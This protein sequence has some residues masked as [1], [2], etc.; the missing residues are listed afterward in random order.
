[1]RTSLR[2]R[3]APALA[4][5]VAA[6]AFSAVASASASASSWVQGETSM[7]WTSPSITL[8]SN[9]TNVSCSLSSAT[10]TT[11]SG[12]AGLVYNSEYFRT[13]LTCPGKPQL[14]FLAYFEV[15]PKNGDGTYPIYMWNLWSGSYLLA[16]SPF[17]EYIQET[18]YG[19]TQGTF[20]NGTGG[21]A[22]TITFQNDVLGYTYPAEK[23][24]TIS[25]TF[26]VTQ[27]D[28]SL[29]TLQGS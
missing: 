21:T 6:L 25:G 16:G 7:K 12:P 20:T 19:T 1:M 15:G 23:A 28:G 29:L 5:V 24:I 14:E 8:S 3:K 18:E 10:G 17:G 27:E 4:A 11:I 9:G 26:K 13:S 2:K 22:S